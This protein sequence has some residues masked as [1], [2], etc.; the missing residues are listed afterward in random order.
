V[1][2]ARALI[3]LILAGALLAACDATVRKPSLQVPTAPVL[4]GMHHLYDAGY[5]FPYMKKK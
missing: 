2:L 3:W 5:V 1:R 4:A